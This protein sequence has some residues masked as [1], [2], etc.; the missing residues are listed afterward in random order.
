MGGRGSSFGVSNKGM[1]YGTEFKSVL[2]VGNI[3]FLKMADPNRSITLPLETQTKNR[4]YVSIKNDKLKSISFYGKNG[5]RV[6][7]IDLDHA[8]KI[9]KEYVVPHTH[10]GYYHSEDGTRKLNEKEYEIIDKIQKIWQTKSV[11]K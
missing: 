6:K 2:H 5:K 9:G 8:H 1:P 11:K 10:V 3:K 7:Q 4:I